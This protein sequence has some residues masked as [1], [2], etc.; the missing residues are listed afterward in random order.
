MQIMSG[1]WERQTSLSSSNLGKRLLALKKITF[2][3]VEER[4]G[5]EDGGGFERGVE[6]GGEEDKEVGKD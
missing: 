1:E 2:S 5:V 3:R 6:E 4:G